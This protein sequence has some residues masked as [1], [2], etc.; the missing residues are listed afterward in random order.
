[1]ITEERRCHSITRSQLSNQKMRIRRLF[2]LLLVFVMLIGMIPSSA[3]A[4]NTNEIY[5]DEGYGIVESARAEAQEAQDTAAVTYDPQPASMAE[6]QAEIA[7]WQAGEAAKPRWQLDVEPS[8]IPAGYRC[9]LVDWDG[10]FGAVYYTFFVVPL[11]AN[12]TVSSEVA[13]QDAISAAADSNIFIDVSVI[14]LTSP[15]VINLDAF[16]G[17]QL[18]LTSTIGSTIQAAP[19]S[20]HIKLTGSGTLVL[21]GIILGGG[22][23]PNTGGIDVGTNSLSAETIT[24]TTGSMMDSII[25]NNHALHGGGLFVNANTK[26][27]LSGNLII[28]GN[29]A[30][31]RGGGIYMPTLGVSQSLLGELNIFG[32]VKISGNEAGESGGGIYCESNRTSISGE[33]LISDNSADSA[34]GGIYAAGFGSGITISENVGI[35]NNHTNDSSVGFGGGIMV[36]NVNAKISGNVDIYD[37]DSASYGGGVFINNGDLEISDNVQIYENIA[38]YQGGGIH[39][40]FGS[41]VYQHGGCVHHNKASSGGGISSWGAHIFL[42]GNTTINDNKSTSNTGGGIRLGSSAGLGA[43]LNTSGDVVISNNESALHGG[44]IYVEKALDDGQIPVVIGGSTKIMDNTALGIGGGIYTVDLSLVSVHSQLG[45]SGNSA[46]IDY[47]WNISAPMSELEEDLKRIHQEHIFTSQFTGSYNNAYNNYD[48]A[49]I[50]LATLIIYDQNSGSGT[51]PRDNTLYSSG[52]TATI[53]GPGA[54]WKPLYRFVGW[55]E[56]PDGLGPMYQKDDTVIMTRSIY[57]FAIWEQVT[58]NIKVTVYDSFASTPLL[59]ATVILECPSDIYRM[60]TTDASGE[61]LFTPL[62][63]GLY[64]VTAYL[65]GYTPTSSSVQLLGA[66]EQSWSKEIDI[67]LPISTP[68]FPGAEKIWG[69]V[70]DAATGIA[71]HNAQVHGA[72]QTAVSGWD[73]YYEITGAGPGTYTMTASYPGYTAQVTG[74]TLDSGV[75]TCQD[76]ALDADGGNAT[77]IISGLVTDASTGNPIAGAVVEDGDGQ[78][79]LTDSAGFYVLTGYMDSQTV[80]LTASMTGYVSETE[81]VPIAGADAVQDF[82]LDIY[83]AG[84][85]TVKWVGVTYREDE[86]TLHEADILGQDG[87]TETI[88]IADINALYQVNNRWILDT[89]RGASLP[90]SITYDMDEDQ[91]ITLYF[92]EDSDENQIPDKDESITVRVKGMSDSTSLYEYEIVKRHTEANFD[93]EAWTIERYR[94]SAGESNT[95]TVDLSTT[96]GREITI[97]FEYESNMTRVT[98][99][100][101]YD[102]TSIPVSGFTQFGVA[103]EA[104]KSFTA[105][106]PVIAG[107][108][109]TSANPVGGSIASVAADDSSEI[110][111]YYKELTGNVTVIYWDDDLNAEFGRGSETLTTNVS[112][113][114][115]IPNLP[116]YTAVSTTAETITFDGV[117]PVP[118]VTYYYT[119]NKVSVKLVAYDSLTS[120]PISGQTPVMVPGLR[121]LEHYDY[122]TDIVP[123]SGYRYVPTGSTS[124]VVPDIDNGEYKVYYKPLNDTQIPV[125]IRVDSATG[126][127]LYSYT[128]NADMG[129]NVTVDPP[130]IAGYEYDS[131]SSDNKLSTT[132]GSGETLMVIL[133][134]VRLTVDVKVKTGSGSQLPYI[135]YKVVSGEYFDVYAPYMS[136]YVLDEYSIDDGPVTAA[137]T[138][139]ISL[140]NIT[141]DHIVLFIYKALDEVVAD[142]YVTL[143]VKGSDGIGELYSYTMLVPKDTA[144]TIPAPAV[145]MYTLDSIEGDNYSDGTTAGTFGEYTVKLSADSTHTFYYIKD[146]ALVMVDFIDQYTGSTISGQNPQTV[147]GI[148]G[149]TITVN[150]PAIS[151]YELISAEPVTKIHTITGTFDLDIVTFTYKQSDGNVLF[152]YVDENN[153][154]NI[155]VQ[156]SESITVDTSTAGM[157]PTGGHPLLPM[158]WELLSGTGTPI[159]SDIAVVTNTVATFKLAKQMETIT[160]NYYAQVTGTLVATAT[161]TTGQV[162]Q[163]IYVLAAPTDLA[164][165]YVLVGNAYDVITVSSGGPNVVDFYYED[166][167]GTGAGAV[168]V[169]GLDPGGAVIHHSIGA[170]MSIG[171]PYSVAAPTLTGWTSATWVSTSDP[172]TGTMAISG[173]TVIYEY[174]MNTVE[175]PIYV[176][177]AGGNPLLG[178]IYLSGTH[179]D[180][181]PIQIGSS[182][183]IYAPHFTG[184][185]VISSSSVAI[186]NADN[187]DSATFQYRKTS[188]DDSVLVQC[189]DTTKSA[190]N[191]IINSWVKKG[192]IGHSFTVNAPTMPN[193]QLVASETPSKAGVY[194]TDTSIVFRYEPM[195]VDVTIYAKN[196]SNS[197]IPGYLPIVVNNVTTGMEYKTIAPVIGGYEIADGQFERSIPSVSDADN[198]ITFIY[199]KSTGNIVIKAVEAGNPDKVIG[200]WYDSANV[201]DTYDATAQCFMG[202]TPESFPSITVVDGQ[203]NVTIEYTKKTVSVI[204]KAVED[205]TGMQKDIKTVLNIQVGTQYT[206]GM[207]FVPGYELKVGEPSAKSINVTDSTN[208]IV[209]TYVPSTSNVFIIHRDT[210]TGEILSVSSDDWTVFDTY[211]ASS[212][213]FDGYVLV[214]SPTQSDTVPDAPGYLVFYFEYEKNFGTVTVELIDS[215]DSSVITSYDADVQ[216]D[217]DTGLYAPPLSGYTLDDVSYQT[218]KISVGDSKTIQF[219]Y[220][221]IP[222][223]GTLTV[224]VSIASSGTAQPGATV[225]ITHGSTTLPYTTDSSGVVMINDVPFGHYSITA[226]YSGYDP[227]IGSTTLSADSHTSSVHIALGRNTGGGGGGGTNGEKY[228]V[229]YDV[230]GGMGSYVI[231]GITSGTTHRI[232]SQTGTGISY[233]GHIFTDWNTKADGSGSSY[234]PDDTITVNGSVTLYAQWR[235]APSLTQDHIVYLSGYPGGGVGPDNNLTRAEAAMIFFRL[236][237]ETVH[238]DKNEPVPNQFSDI[239]D[240][241]WYAQAVNYLA[242]IGI[243]TGVEDGT[244]QPERSIY[245]AEFA[246]IASRFDVLEALDANAF[247][248]VPGSHWAVAFI[249]SAAV[250]GWITGFPDGMFK[251]ENAITRG[252]TVTLVNR[253]LNRAIDDEALAAIQN[254]YHDIDSSHWAYTAIMEAAIH[255]EYARDDDGREHWILN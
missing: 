140:A 187:S 134:D 9:E 63:L 218:V 144:T 163:S 156:V 98:I 170:A 110:V 109:N 204:I 88:D 210:D 188:S 92:N 49:S 150:A 186:T 141:T 159:Y 199:K 117:A 243:V 128:I 212:V 40:Q 69:F 241:E 73:G 179:Y 32:N 56:D 161:T 113:T 65:D 196:Q 62:T 158:G 25:E 220:K 52:D 148:I 3:L 135:S 84:K 68:P 193:Y 97:V 217:K 182:V 123:I 93:V 130:T 195:T 114:I 142:S 226:T 8:L 175:I 85:V 51:P 14:T 77:Y 86:F 28:R 155:L 244:F 54:L 154:S 18:T 5:P 106:A 216:Y 19:G 164:P 160:V 21:N 45:F 30:T 70:T 11:A 152:Q 34:G 108:T 20:R 253:M 1:M 254:P 31:A 246:T 36:N 24:I 48:I 233:T 39:A 121:V 87:T 249:N 238:E 194:G 78:S 224:T 251:P 234:S 239:T 42:D 101:Y 191:N 76:F 169:I 103:A 107:F 189:V 79:T 72:G 75:N 55:C 162:G 207:L 231:T 145:P 176:T 178:V 33:V 200:V 211:T 172:E 64:T 37:N 229:T 232:L 132:A 26:L 173:V 12:V 29:Q 10:D 100:A 43:S 126:I 38:A 139:Q 35:F 235:E 22:I 167:T 95:K 125:E 171:D 222:T 15:L 240:T 67:Y 90:A 104:G 177:D 198:S 7:A 203:N 133:T 248:D 4:A 219:K 228:T 16:A 209:F 250:K 206:A 221:A 115:P 184:Y 143:T 127:L 66:N 214:G 137:T 82:A 245:R 118:N 129:E 2:S 255:H 208:E 165:G 146:T 236:L 168:T 96:V 81:T 94:L 91:T 242:S 57:L 174:E 185:E 247:S 41:N 105:Y 153:L 80:A 227:G 111:F 225:Q 131:D 215:G 50:G 17:N 61:V 59:G 13:L 181:R 166:R 149:E 89:G 119:K 252:E 53:S 202:W 60:L 74:V 213:S 223:S 180:N 116:N 122:Y 190:P 157:I 23:Q 83:K 102:G 147:T 124:I 6:V 197:N 46:S 192:D 151:D 112:T 201:G 138:E 183:T 120:M 205:V 44:G 136:G 230:N 237:S 27:T 99:K 47:P 58:P 71:I